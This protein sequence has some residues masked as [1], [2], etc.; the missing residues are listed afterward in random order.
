[1]RISKSEIE[2][3]KTSILKTLPNYQIYLFGSRVDDNKRGG[4]IDIFV[5][6][7]I[8]TSLK[9]K[10]SILTDIEA[11][12]IERKIDLIV[13][14]PNSKEQKIFITAEKEGILL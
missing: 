13:K 12:G 4:D 1:L 3:I 6:T 9:D 7:D 5:Q 8:E 10:I 14:S 11:N 2:I